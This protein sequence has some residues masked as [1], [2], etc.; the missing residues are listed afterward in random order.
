M[1]NSLNRH[2][3]FGLSQIKVK[4]F[5]L[6]FFFIYLA[7]DFFKVSVL[8]FAAHSLNFIVALLLLIKDILGIS[9]DA[10]CVLLLPLLFFYAT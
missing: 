3:F 7:F 10:V 4:K 6:V 5:T 1:I 9:R 8:G 2:N